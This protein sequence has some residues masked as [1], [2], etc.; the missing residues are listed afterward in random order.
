MF[1]G[2]GLL[3]CPMCYAVFSERIEGA[4]SPSELVL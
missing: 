3:G 4:A 1:E 2:T